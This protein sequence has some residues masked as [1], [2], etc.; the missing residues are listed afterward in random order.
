MKTVGM[1]EAKTKL[2]ELCEQVAETREP[3][4]VTRRGTPYVR[5]DPIDKAPATI[6]ERRMAYTVRY[7]K[8]EARDKKDF[9]PAPR[10][11]EVSDFDVSG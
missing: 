8:A 10:S 1:F 4:V 9:E 5:I 7:G 2:S 11:R 6:Q 3:V